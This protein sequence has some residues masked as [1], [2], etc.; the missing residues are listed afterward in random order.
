M[1][2]CQIAIVSIEND[3]HALVFQKA[4]EKYDGLRCHIVESNRICGSKALS[5][6]SVEGSGFECRLPTKEGGD[7]LEVSKL[8]VIWWRRVGFPQKI[9]FNIT[10]P[11]HVD[12]IENDC[13][14]ALTGLLLNE[15]RGTWINHP[16]NTLLA[17]NKLVQLR[18]A[19][20][21]GFRVPRTIVSQNPTAIR[22][23]CE[24]LDYK[25]IVKPIRGARKTPMFTSMVTPAH[26]TC[27]DSI[28]LCPAIYQEYISGEMHVR[29]QCFGDAIYSVII[30][31]Q[32]LDWRVN[33]D[34][35]VIANNLAEDVKT[36]LRN[37]LK[38]L[39]LKMGVVDL[40]LTPEGELVWFEINPQGQFL[41]VEGLSGLDLTSAFTDFLYQE[42][43][44][45]AKC[46]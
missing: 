17:G 7:N 41:F 22:H 36:R 32:D 34:V 35:P 30:K 24:G 43:R 44:K 39:G 33:L 19:Q 16:I 46:I 20:D 29:V 21:A 23:F 31:S 4:L 14:A 42:A 13:R 25:V 8:D 15:F 3:L 18:A 1:R 6:S 26:L 45:A 5:W 12:V 11:A 38:L 27:E 28:A 10:D 40:K 9:P 2:P 37:V